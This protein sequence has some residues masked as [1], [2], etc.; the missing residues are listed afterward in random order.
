[1]CHLAGL[2]RLALGETGRAQPDHIQHHMNSTEFISTCNNSVSLRVYMQTCCSPHLFLLSHLAFSLWHLDI[3]FSIGQAV[4]CI[5]S[6]NGWF[7]E[8]R[9]TG[10][11]LAEDEKAG[12]W[13]V[14]LARRTGRA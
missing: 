11:G 10:I 5:N 4:Q 13:Q 9:V 6:E 7:Y 2:T 3:I 8:A 1:M 12:T 14:R